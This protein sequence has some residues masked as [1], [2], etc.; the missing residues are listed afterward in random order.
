MN[1][2]ENGDFHLVGVIW[3]NKTLEDSNSITYSAFIRAVGNPACDRNDMGTY[4]DLKSPR[5]FSYP[6]YIDYHDDNYTGG[7]IKTW[8]IQP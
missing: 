6:G 8:W 4:I 2:E 7:P 3:D 5:V 1:P